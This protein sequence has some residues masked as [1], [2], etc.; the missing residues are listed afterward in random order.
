[1]IVAE[2]ARREYAGCVAAMYQVHVRTWCWRAVLFG[3]RL[4]GA[5]AMCMLANTCG[6]HVLET[7]QVYLGR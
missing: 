2:I 7:S 4:L 1:M 5:S 3:M 6:W